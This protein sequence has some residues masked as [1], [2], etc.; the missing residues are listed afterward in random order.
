VDA[1]RRLTVAQIGELR[2]T[3]G[4][5]VVLFLT[6]RCPVGCAHCSVSSRADSSRI[7]DWDL[8]AEVIAGVCALAGVQAVAITGGEPFAERRGLTYAVQQLHAAG[9]DLVVF[10]SGYWAR[11]TTAGWVGS[12]LAVTSTV[13][14]ST[15]SFHSAGLAKLPRNDAASLPSGP[16]GIGRQRDGGSA[17]GSSGAGGGGAPARH[18]VEVAA[19]LIEDAG[20]HLVLQVLDE[21]GAMEAARNVSLNAE[22]SLVQPIPV[23]RGSSTFPRGGLRPIADLGRCSL[24]NSPTIR[25]DGWVSACCNESVITGSGPQALRRRVARARDVGDALRGFGAD[26]VLRL[27]GRHGAGALEALADPP[28]RTVCDACWSVHDKVA[29]DPRSSVVLR[30]LGERG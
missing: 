17:G 1:V 10:T 3:P 5:T 19:Q 12:V 18:A 2:R 21:P 24:L 25:Y 29:A 28:F 26:P 6:D 22:V 7:T 11:G 14:L 8:F 27:I 4:A 13:Y 30:L 20:C 9:K 16:R 15:D 23:G